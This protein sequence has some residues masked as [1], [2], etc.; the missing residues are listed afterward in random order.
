MVSHMVERDGGVDD[1]L[2]VLQLHMPLHPFDAA[3]SLP[4]V[5]CGH[6]CAAHVLV[7]ALA[8]WPQSAS[9]LRVPD[10][11]RAVA[12]ELSQFRLRAAWPLHDS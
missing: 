4:L 11:V 9:A 3:P 5:V 6:K 7:V 8:E 1:L 12:V 10:R 2:A